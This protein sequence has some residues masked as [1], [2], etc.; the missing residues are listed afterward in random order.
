[1]ENERYERGRQV[2]RAVLGD[3]YVD[4]AAAN[5]TELDRDFQRFIAGLMLIAAEPGRNSATI[6][7]AAP[8]IVC[9]LPQESAP[10]PCGSAGGEPDCRY[11]RARRP[12]KPFQ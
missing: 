3:E 12:T 2:R 1:M 10:C 5:Q 8:T 9:G 4:R 7:L 11:P 6:R